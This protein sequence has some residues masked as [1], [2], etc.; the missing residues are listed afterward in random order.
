[1]SS[2]N[3][4]LSRRTVLGGLAAAGAVPLLTPAGA[5]SASGV[6]APL[7]SD[8]RTKVVV[9]GTSG[10]PGWGTTEPQRRGIASALVV[11]D[12][13]Y[14]VDTGEGVGFRLMDAKLGN[15]QARAALSDLRAVFLAHL[16]SD[17]IND[18]SNILSLGADNGLV[19]ADRPVPVWGPG[20]RGVLPPKTGAH[21]MP[22]VTAPD[23]PT[24]GTRMAR[25][26]DVL[27][28]EVIATEWAA[29]R[30]PE[31]RSPE[32]EAA[33][34]HLI[35]S[36]TPVEEVGVIAEKAGVPTPVLNHVVPGSWPLEKW[37]AAQQGYSGRLVV[38]A[39][40]DEIGLKVRSGRHVCP[41]GAYEV[42]VGLARIP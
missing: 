37:Q 38:G 36:H 30:Y 16:H 19:A 32:D 26:A 24:P 28:H 41:S 14:L 12:R 40:L 9:L 6:A 15:W 11:G 8:A 2:R 23:N 29:Q 21:P 39:D 3:P 35:K 27:V 4:P 10:G 1:M 18:L 5:A 25:G 33:F 22:P 7:R 13:Y 20:N 31:P 17:H 42:S 34:Q